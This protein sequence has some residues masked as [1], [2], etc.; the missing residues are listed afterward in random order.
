MAKMGSDYELFVQKL[1]QALLDSEPFAEQHNITVERNKKI[2]D[3]IGIEREFDLYWEYTLAGITYKTI[4]ECKDYSSRISIEKID[5]LIGKLHDLPDIKPVFA[6]KIGYQSGAE[7]KARQ[8]KIDLLIVREQNHDDWQ[9]EDGNPLIK[10]IEINIHMLSPAHV[11]NFQPFVDKEW[12]L[13]ET[14]IDISKPLNFSGLSNEIYLENRQTKEKYSLYELFQRLGS[15]K[16]Q[17]GNFTEKEEFEDAYIHHNDSFYKLRG[18]QINY[19]LF[20][21]HVETIILDYANE[22][23]GVIE[24][25][26][27]GKITAVFKDRVIKEWRKK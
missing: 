23:I 21:P 12:I 16:N 4:I 17:Y 24:Y 15:G 3:N 5:A 20:P 26:N 19:Q 7:A 13:Q 1:Q 10:Q 22:L 2:I 11:T 14:D 18:Y 25:L 8:N 27:Q 9:D 6:T